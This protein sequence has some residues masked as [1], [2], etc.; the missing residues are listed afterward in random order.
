M[1]RWHFIGVGGSGMAP[2]AHLTAARGIEI[3]GS[4]RAAS[5]YFLA[6]QE[7]GAN[8]VVGHDPSLVDGADAVVVST[9]IRDTNPELAR[10]RE[11]GIPV[12][13]MSEALVEAF[14]GKRIVAVAGTHG[15]TTTSAMVVRALHGAGIDAS[16]MIGAKVFGVD[17]AVAGGFVGASDVAVVEA[18][19][20]N[21]SFLRYHPEVGI[22]L[23]MEPDHLDFHGSVEALYGAFREFM[24]TCGTVVAC[25]EDATVM[26]T[27]AHAGTTVVTYGAESSAADVRVGPRSLSAAGRTWDLDVPIPGAHNRLNAAAAIEAAVLMGADRDLAVAALAGFSGTGRRFQL[28][29]EAAG[30][31]VIDD[32]AH[33]PTEVAAVISAA[34]DAGAGRLV[35]L[36]Q[37]ALFTRTLEHRQAFADALSIPDADIVMAGVYGD[38]EDPIPGVTSQSVVDLMRLPES[39]T[40]RAVEDLEEAAHEAARLA[41]PGDTLLTVGS[42]TVTKAPDWILADL[43]GGQDGAS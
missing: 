1:T 32:Y 10:A 5:K 16:F 7:S 22:V 43:A 30:V 2:V 42:G 28:R 27:A 38:R 20:S 11:L 15:K 35:V 8:V 31:R 39:S 12:K 34:R 24:G 17:G 23:N 6:L 41:R 4:D 19:E 26:T 29:G 14:A 40:A 3:S 33:H 9:A 37:P 18:D 21:G 13:H 36:F 25:A